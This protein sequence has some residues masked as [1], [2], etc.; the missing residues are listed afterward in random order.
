MKAEN[1]A[2]RAAKALLSP[3]GNAGAIAGF[4]ATQVADPKMKKRLFDA[5][6]H[7]DK[8]NRILNKVVYR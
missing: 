5:A 3:L 2:K 4:H 1:E 8:A 7:A 6:K